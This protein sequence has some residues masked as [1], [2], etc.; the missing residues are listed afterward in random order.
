MSWDGKYRNGRN[1]IEHPHDVEQY[2]WILFSPPT[3][4]I[5]VGKEAFQSM[6]YVS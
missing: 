3:H 6:Y 4:V 1:G 2:Q 5:Q